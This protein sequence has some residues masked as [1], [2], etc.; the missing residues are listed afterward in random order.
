MDFDG[1]AIATESPRALG[2]WYCEL[3]GAQR[4]NENVATLG[5]LQL[6]FF[7]HDNVSG[8]NP[9][10]ERIMINFAVPDAAAFA[11]H[12]DGLEVEW[13]RRF[14]PEA[15]GLLATI[16]DPDGNFVQFTHHTNPT[17]NAEGSSK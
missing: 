9:Q 6:V 5:P 7:P 10:P 15:F 11:A 4:E 16:A 8:S 3:L 14:E 2:D 12:A 17:D 1:F 13:I